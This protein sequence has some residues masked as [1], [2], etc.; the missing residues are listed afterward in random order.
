MKRPEPAGDH[1]SMP[2]IRP[3][4]EA[5]SDT[6]GSILMVG[7][8]VVVA[9]SL[10]LL[11]LT[12]EG[13]SPALHSD[14]AIQIDPGNGGWGT[15]DEVVRVL[16]R[17]GDPLPSQTAVVVKVGNTATT[18]TGATLGST[19]ADGVLRIGETWQKTA[20]I[21]QGAPVK[22]SVLDA[23]PGRSSILSSGDFIASALST[24]QPCASDTSMP[25]VLVWSQSP[26]TITALT[27]GAVTVTA[28]V[29]DDCWGVNPNVT[30]TFQWRISPASSTY[31]DQGAMTPSGLNIWRATIPAQTW[32]NYV[33]QNL[34]YHISLLTD[35]AGNTG[36]TPDH[37]STIQADCHTDNL[38]PVAS[39]LT[40][41]P[42][43][44]QTSTSGAVTVTVVVA[45]DCA[46]VDTVTNPTLYY[47][48]NDGTNPAFTN[49]GAMT[50]TTG[51]TWT[52][53][54]PSQTWA[55]LA[56]KTMQ[57]YVSGMRDNNGNLGTSGTN[58]DLVDI[59]ATYNYVNSNTPTTGTVSFFANAQSASD[60]GAEATIAEGG[61]PQTPVTVSFNANAVVNANGWTTASNAFASDNAYAT[62]ATNSPASSNDLQLGLQD[63]V[64]TTGTITS[65][66][67]H[68]EVSIVSQNN[69]GFQL[70]ACLAG[71]SCNA[72]G[73]VGG[74]S[75]VDTT[76]NYDITAVRPGGGSWSWSDITNL[77]GVL[78]LEQPGG[79]DGTWR[80]DRVWVDV[81]SITST[82]STSVRMDWSAVPAGVTHNLE[83]RYRASVDTFTLEV[84]NGLAYTN[85][86]TLSSTTATT[87]TYTMTV[88]EYN[89]GAPR[90]RITDNSPTGTT[91][92]N[93]YIDYARVATL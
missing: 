22:V 9:A 33:G 62:Y 12:F 61:T 27:T 69:D 74:Q 8:T 47:R 68:A 88:A 25:T 15:G 28:Q 4:E 84:W 41:S 65:V 48:F 82:Y 30:P 32:G 49:G 52:G 10:G 57:Y 11:L 50:R 18:Y 29:T 91:Q 16:H 71:G 55:L 40:Q 3:G 92:A 90:I 37:A 26:A 58:A 43:D 39:S 53:T 66:I 7:I 36:T 20:N 5:V 24:T 77:Q 21:P 56:G 63:P 83:L 42:T 59:F 35:L 17:G 76:M 44:V 75:A 23:G 79:R 78:R 51:T 45:D 2:T 86:G 64:V 72:L 80:V 87:F 14:L 34:Q 46:G 31:T 89:A 85:R 67:L 13:P 81:T 38:P 70:Y 73:G 60:S 93:L 6:I 1:D 54:I 19:W